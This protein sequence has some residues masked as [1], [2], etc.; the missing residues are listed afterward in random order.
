MVTLP[1][2]APAS[3][4][5]VFGSVGIGDMDGD[6]RLDII[7][8]SSEGLGRQQLSDAIAVITTATETTTRAVL[9]PQLADSRPCRFPFFPLIGEE[10][11]SSPAIAD[12]DGDDSR[13][14]TRPRRHRQRRH[15]PS[16]A[17]C[18][19]RTCDRRPSRSPGPWRSAPRCAVRL[20]NVETSRVSFI[21]ASSLGGFGD[22][23]N[24]GVPD[25]VIPCASLGLAI[26]LAGGGGPFPI[27][28]LSTRA[29][30][31][32]P[33]ATP[34]LPRRV[35]DYTFFFQLPC[36]ADVGGDACPRCHRPP[37]T[38]SAA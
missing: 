21:P 12:M 3:H 35:E 10:V 23:T 7:S 33:P 36:I 38:T 9:P 18:S 5:R 6:R 20:T 8:V 30:G 31:T 24:D 27:E 34:R 37:A 22:M 14:E 2:T 26:N 29:P 13:D 28:R 16:P 32:A 1:G 11:S 17:A 4:S 15:H 19:R 25:S